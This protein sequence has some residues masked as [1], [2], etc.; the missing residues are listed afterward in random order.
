MHADNFMGFNLRS[1]AFICG[2]IVCGFQLPLRRPPTKAAQRR[3]EERKLPARIGMLLGFLAATTLA[4]Q[5]FPPRSRTSAWPR[6]ELLAQVSFPGARAADIWVHGEYAWLGAWSC[7]H[8][9]KVVDISNPRQ[10]LALD[11]LVTDPGSTSEDVVV[12][13]ADTPA[14]RGDLLAVGLQP[15][16]AGGAKGVQFWDV[17]DPRSP[18][19]LGFV[20]TDV[21]NIGVHELHLFQRGDRVFALLAVPNSEVRYG[22]GDFRIVEA[23][24]PA[25]PREIARWGILERLGPQ[26]EVPSTICHSAWTNEQGSIAFLSYWA[27]GVVML[28]ITEPANP[29]FLGRTG[30]QPG[31]DG[32]AHSVWTAKDGKVL[33]VADEDFTPGRARLEITEPVSLAGPLSASEL[34]FPQTVCRGGDL[35]GDV[36]YV[37]RG[38]NNDQYLTSPAGA[39]PLIDDGA[40]TFGEKA[41]RAQAAGAVAV[42]VARAATGPPALGNTDSVAIPGVLLSAADGARLQTALS[43]GRLRVALRADPNDT[44]GFLRLFDI[45][46]PSSP[47]P[48]GTFATPHSRQCPPPGPGWYTIHNPFVVGDTAFLS[49]YADGVRMVDISDPANP[50]ELAFFVPPENPAVWGVYARD[51]LVFLSDINNGLFILRRRGQ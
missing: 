43:S 37:G 24:D 13:R 8:G 11:A 20:D 22:Q 17:T 14:F 5:M 45:S 51:D 47:A 12:I 29:R 6:L 38:C 46:N 42:I 35:A 28:D 10:P 44:W 31:E 49:W 40:C 9:V 2:F 1:S 27:A 33:L 16:R 21:P 4:A 30:Y 23:T 25:N 50:R 19:K 36:F 7:G 39:I 15:C 48:I 34:P 3:L 26:S 41:L 32:N 18:R